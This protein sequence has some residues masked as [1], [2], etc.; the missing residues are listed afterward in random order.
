MAS[1]DDPHLSHYL[2]PWCRNGLSLNEAH[3]RCL[4]GGKFDRFW[5]VA[6]ASIEDVPLFPIRELAAGRLLP[7]ETRTVLYFYLWLIAK[8]HRADSVRASRFV[9]EPSMKVDIGPK[10]DSVAR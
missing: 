8:Q 1:P 4:A 6:D 9:P 7:Q 3:E 10:P 2:C 5:P